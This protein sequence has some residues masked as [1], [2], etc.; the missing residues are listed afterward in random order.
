MLEVHTV[1]DA[2]RPRGDEVARDHP[3][4]GV[5]HRRIGQALAEG[6]FYLVAQLA[7]GLLRAVQ[8]HLVGDADAVRILGRMALGLE[9]LVHLRA[10]TVHQHDLHAHALDHG[11]VLREVRQFACGNRLTRDAD[12]KGLVAELVDVGRNRPEPG[13]EGEIEN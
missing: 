9:L 8:R 3:H 7:G 12:H 6:G 10:K 5:G 11:Q 4:R 1:D 13:H 2:H